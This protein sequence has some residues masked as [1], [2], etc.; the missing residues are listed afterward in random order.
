MKAIT[1]GRQQASKL[2]IKLI[3]PYSMFLKLASLQTGSAFGVITAVS[4]NDTFVAAD[5]TTTAIYS[6]RGRGV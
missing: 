4:L 1:N 3:L 6:F 5:M 2:Q